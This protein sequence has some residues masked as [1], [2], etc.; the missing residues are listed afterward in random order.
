MT[1][2]TPPPPP[3]LPTT[4]PPLLTTAA[5]TT[6]ILL[7][8]II[9]VYRKYKRAANITKLILTLDDIVFIDT[10]VSRKVSLLQSRVP[11]NSTGTVLVLTFCTTANTFCNATRTRIYSS[12]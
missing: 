7:I 1:L 5:S 11:T 4:P 3:P 2:P 6:S 10:Q 9:C 12:Y 8:M